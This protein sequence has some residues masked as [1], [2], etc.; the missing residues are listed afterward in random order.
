M[1]AGGL[2]AVLVPHGAAARCTRAPQPELARGP[3]VIETR[4][5]PQRFSVEQAQ[6]P[7]E[8]AC[9]LMFRQKLAADEG[10]LFDYR[11]GQP[12]FM[13]ME[14]TVIPLDMVFIAPDGRVAHLVERAVPFSREA[15][16][17]PQIVAGVLEL[18]GGSIAR[19]GI[20][21]GDTVR[22]EWFGTPP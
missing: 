8:K 3:L 13:W 14:N 4:S 7:E 16:G 5:G 9:G 18:A 6:G 22:H 11:P 2:A 21:P 17:T 1:L 20:R 15:V 10:M 12:A 19:L